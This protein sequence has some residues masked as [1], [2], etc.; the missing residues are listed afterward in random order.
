MNQ[1]EDELA[2]LADPEALRVNDFDVRNAVFVIP[3]DAPVPSELA[4]VDVP[5]GS[6]YTRLSA[7]DTEKR[8]DFAF[9]PLSGTE[10]L[11]LDRAWRAL[12]RAP[13]VFALFDLPGAKYDILFT[14]AV[15][16]IGVARIEWPSVAEAMASRVRTVQR[17]KDSEPWSVRSNKVDQPDAA[18]KPRFP[19]SGGSAVLPIPEGEEDE[20]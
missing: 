4:E 1:I 9:V 19:R 17:A 18:A 2:P 5:M 7:L 16:Q 14:Q 12:Q 20:D 11:S 8:D 6:L 15:R 10:L 13:R 3:I